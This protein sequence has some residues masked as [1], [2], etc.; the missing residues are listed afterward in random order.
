MRWLCCGVLEDQAKSS[1][2]RGCFVEK[3]RVLSLRLVRSQTNKPSNN[4]ARALGRSNATSPRAAS[5]SLS[6]PG[7]MARR[8]SG[9][10]SGLRSAAARGRGPIAARLLRPRQPGLRSRLFSRRKR[11]RLLARKT[12][13]KKINSKKKRTQVHA[14]TKKQITPFRVTPVGTSSSTVEHYTEMCE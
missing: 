14:L 13:A 4:R 10:A 7:C 5:P 1:Q 12:R 11:T 8:A 9:T 2:K 6:S 3:G